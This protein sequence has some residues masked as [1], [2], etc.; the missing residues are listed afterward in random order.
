M[1]AQKN[2]SHYCE[3]LLA[4]QSDM[5]NSIIAVDT[6]L[7]LEKDNGFVKR[8]FSI[9]WSRI[10]WQQLILSVSRLLDG[11]KRTMS[12][13]R[14]FS[15]LREDDNF[16]GDNNF[17]SAYIHFKNFKDKWNKQLKQIKVLRDKF[18]AHVDKDIEKVLPS[19]FIDPDCITIDNYKDT[20]EEL[21]S[22]ILK[23]SEIVISKMQSAKGCDK[24]IMQSDLE[25]KRRQYVSALAK[26]NHM[27]NFCVA[28]EKLVTNI[29]ADH[30]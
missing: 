2:N 30:F 25:S 1:D 9:F 28:L 26:I 19:L 7:F 15:G 3:W 12:L 16:K 6:I 10:F 17:E 20:I 23:I 21:A 11:D 24:L 22:I 8:Y 14:L 5:I 27:A 18:Y 29:C 4:I 13:S